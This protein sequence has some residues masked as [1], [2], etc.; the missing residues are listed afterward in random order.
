MKQFK[1]TSSAQL[2]R[3][4]ADLPTYDIGALPHRV[5]RHNL[6]LRPVHPAVG[7]PHAGAEPGGGERRGGALLLV[8]V[9]H[10]E[11]DGELVDAHALPAAPKLLRERRKDHLLWTRHLRQ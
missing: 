2:C 11:A 3:R 5:P 7:H 8:H 10:D 6:L 4:Q 9:V 1:N